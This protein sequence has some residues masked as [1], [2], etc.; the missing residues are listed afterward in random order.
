MKNIVCW[1]Q[2]KWQ[3]WKYLLIVSDLEMF[4]EGLFNS[5]VKLVSIILLLKWKFFHLQNNSTELPISWLKAI[6]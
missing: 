4:W 3:V 1:S 6:L 2:I 5:I